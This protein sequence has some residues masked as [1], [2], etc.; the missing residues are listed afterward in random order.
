MNIEQKIE[1]ILFYRNE[2]VEIKKLAQILDINEGEVRNGLGKLKENLG[3]RGICLVQTEEEASLVTAPEMKDI[4][5]QMTRDEMSK[6]IGKAGLETLAII[7]YNGSA[8]RR[9]IDYIRGVNSTFILRNLSMRGLVE[10]E[11]KEGKERGVKYKPTTSLLAHLGLRTSS[12]LPDFE[13]FK[14]KIER[15]VEEE[16]KTEENAN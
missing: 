5:G 9:E 4:L 12:E 8:G 1:A 11:S 14:Q 3:S 10:K 15:V 6:E 7:L 16:L 2:P 13:E